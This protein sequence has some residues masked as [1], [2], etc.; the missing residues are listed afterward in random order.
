MARVLEHLPAAPLQFAI[1]AFPGKW[2][3]PVACTPATYSP[4]ERNGDV[5]ASGFH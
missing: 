1:T 4:L 2:L 3:V 5:I